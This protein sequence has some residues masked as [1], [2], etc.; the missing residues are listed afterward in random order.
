MEFGPQTLVDIRAF[1]PRLTGPITVGAV[2]MD[3]RFSADALRM[4]TLRM[5]PLVS[6]AVV[7]LGLYQSIEFMLR[8]PAFELFGTGLC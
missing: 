1:K 8:R 6:E 3:R 7:G 5:R 4:I 2:V